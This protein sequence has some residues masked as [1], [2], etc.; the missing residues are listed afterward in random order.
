MRKMLAEEKGLRKRV[1]DVVW[2]RRYWSWSTFDSDIRAFEKS[3]RADERERCAKVAEEAQFLSDADWKKYGKG[4]LKRD[5]DPH[6]NAC[7]DI[8]AAIRSKEG[9]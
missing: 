8:A 2:E 4:K 9:R 1:G 3:V 5:D 7:R 6:N